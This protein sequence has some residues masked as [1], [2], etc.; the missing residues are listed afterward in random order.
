VLAEADQLVVLAN[1]LG[2]A[3]GEVEGERGLVGA[4]VV[5]VEDELA[6]QVLRG[7]PYDPANTGVDE[8]IPNTLA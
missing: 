2:S 8:T 4:E 3:L 5:D 6:G 7:S 1:D